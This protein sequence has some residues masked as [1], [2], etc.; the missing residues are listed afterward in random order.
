MWP[1]EVGITC[2]PG[3]TLKKLAPMHKT[4]NEADAAVLK[5]VQG[6]LVNAY[7]NCP[8]IIADL[9]DKSKTPLNTRSI[10][11]H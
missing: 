9:S 11:T 10:T 5:L 3:A 6:H 8:D 1:D 2:V 7:L 4:A